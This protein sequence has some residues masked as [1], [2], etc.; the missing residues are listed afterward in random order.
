MTIPPLLLLA[1]GRKPRLRR[2]PK[3]RPK[4]LVLHMSVAKLLRDYARPEWQWTHIPSGELRDI[5][6]AS[7]LKQM[8]VRRGWPDFLLVSPR[9][10]LH[11]LELKRAGEDLTED[12]EQFRAWCIVHGAPYVVAWTFDEALAA[13]REWGVLRIDIATAD[14]GGA[15]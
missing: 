6:T 3:V 1:E 2:A 10:S 11:C 8:G 7:K 12:Q 13:L 4:E 9:G 15:Q 5:R 14:H